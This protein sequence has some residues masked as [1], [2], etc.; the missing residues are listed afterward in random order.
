MGRRGQGAG[1]QLGFSAMRVRS[2]LMTSTARRRVLAVFVLAVL[3]HVG[4]RA[5]EAKPSTANVSGDWNL[6]IHGDHVMQTGLSLRQDGTKVTGTFHMQG[7]TAAAEGEF[8]DGKLTLEV[9]ASISG[10]HAKK[11]NITK[12]SI[13]ATMKE[14]GTLE[15]EMRSGRG[16]VRIT[17]ERFRTKGKSQRRR[18]TGWIG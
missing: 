12:I 4:L 7:K 3:G 17:A 14:D 18:L 6:S 2:L 8:L 13:L 5:Q 1:V 11:A 16:P 9:D 10:E 15:G